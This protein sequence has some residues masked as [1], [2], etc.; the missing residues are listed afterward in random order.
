MN[1]G[2]TT[3]DVGVNE[4]EYVATSIDVPVLKVAALEYQHFRL[5]ISEETKVPCGVTVRPDKVALAEVT[6]RLYVCST[7]LVVP[8]MTL[9]MPGV[10]LEIATLGKFADVPV[11]VSEPKYDV[12]PV[13]IVPPPSL[14]PSVLTNLMVTSAALLKLVPDNGNAGEVTHDVEAIVYVPIVTQPEPVLLL[15]CMVKC[16]GPVPE[17]LFW[18]EAMLMLLNPVVFTSHCQ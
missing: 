16:A 12:P 7:L 4:E 17:L 13:P 5:L 1:D 18:K 10:V 14:T 3:L 8:C 6:A 9:P 15:A 2:K 11:I